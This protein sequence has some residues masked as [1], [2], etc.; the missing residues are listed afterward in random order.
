MVPGWGNY[1]SVNFEMMDRD[2][3]EEQGK[4]GEQGELFI[5][6]NKVGRLLLTLLML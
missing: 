4:Q 5:P 1:L 2:K 3:Q 6:Q